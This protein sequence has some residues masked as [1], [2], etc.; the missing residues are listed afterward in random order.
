[1]HYDHDQE[2]M[3]TKWYFVHHDTS[4]I[5]VVTVHKKTLHMSEIL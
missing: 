5:K 1:M 3:T 4:A 2:A